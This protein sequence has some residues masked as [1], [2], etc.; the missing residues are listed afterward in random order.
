LQ[1][2]TGRVMSLKR[3]NEIAAIARKHDLTTVEDDIYGP[4]AKG[5]ASPPLAALVPERTFYV[6]SLSKAIAPGLRTGYLLTPDEEGLEKVINAVRAFSYSPA[7]FGPL[8]A[9]QW[10][11]DGT[12]DTIIAEVKRD[13]VARV[14]LA[15]RVL[16]GAIEGPYV[17]AAPHIWLPMSEL[18]AERVSNA[19]LRGGVAVTP[20]SAPIIDG[21]HISGLR[22]CIGAPSDLTTLER[23]LKIVTAALSDSPAPLR[24]VV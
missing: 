3:R 16:A 18:K 20:A 12:A 4:F 15:R 5:E 19:V 7:S 2:P 17:K 21:K 23:K 24:N 9:T 14:E 8:I 11:E 6:T 10:I 13:V 1:N 22:L